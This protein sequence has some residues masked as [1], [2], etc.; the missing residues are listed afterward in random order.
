MPRTCTAKIY[1]PAVKIS[2]PRTFGQCYVLALSI[3]VKPTYFKY[4]KFERLVISFCIDF[5]KGGGA[6]V[7]EKSQAFDSKKVSSPIILT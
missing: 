6:G 5:R 1:M 3:H 4:G 7:L 2:L